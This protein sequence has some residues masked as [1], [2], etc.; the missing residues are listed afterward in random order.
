VLPAAQW[1]EKDWTSTNSERMIA[2]SPRLFDPPGVALPDWQIL[3]R[4]AR[5]LHLPGFDWQDA[6][7]V[8]D[9]LIGLTRTRPCDM[10]GA[11]A[12]RLRA[13]TSLRWP[14]PTPDHP[15]TQR[16]YLDRRFPTHDGRANFL[17]RDHREPRELP[18]HEFP[19]ILTTGRLYAHWH[20]LTRTAKAP[21]LVR[22][23]PGPFVEVHRLDAAAAGLADGETAQLS[24]RRGTIRVPIR[25]SD[26][27]PPGL[28]FVPFHWGDLF[29]PGNATN[30]LTIAATGRVAKQPELKFCAVALA[31][32][33]VAERGPS[34]ARAWP[35][36]ETLRAA[37]VRGRQPVSP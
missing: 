3:A 11:T 12:E 34:S 26:R 25:L 32:V 35:A 29:G 4:F 28:V 14:C 7:A 20:T 37:G 15:G 27:V 16:L 33:P 1:G 13:E 17:P 8:W 22:R 21:K 24:S 10:T 30:Y 19:L 18:D 31:K 2:F 36:Q 6:A 23:E 9:E 5:R